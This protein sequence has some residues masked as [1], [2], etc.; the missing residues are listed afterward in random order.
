MEF[1][2]HGEPIF[3]TAFA[4][5]GLPFARLAVASILALSVAGCPSKDP[6][7]QTWDLHEAGNFEASIPVLRKAIEE[8]ADDPELLFLY[9]VALSETGNLDGAVWPLRKAMKSPEWEVRA[10]LLLAR[11]AFYQNSWDS[12]IDALDRVIELEPDHIFA[13]VTRSR[14]RIETRRDYEGALADAERALEIDPDAQGA[15]ICQVVALLGLDRPEEARKLIG[16]IEL[17]SREAESGQPD[18]ARFCAARATLATELGDAETA[19]KIYSECLKEFPGAPELVAEAVKLYGSTGQA[20]RVIEVLERAVEAAPQ[21]RDFRIGLALRLQSQGREAEATEILRKATEAKSPAVAADAWLDLG[22]Y[23]LDREEYDAGIEA[24]DRALEIVASPSGDLMFRYADALII[25]DRFDEALEVADRAQVTTYRDLIRGR[26]HLAQGQPAL[27]LERLTE[28][29][30]HWP[31]NAVAR[32]YTALAAEGVGNYARAVEEMRYSI[33]AG[34]SRTDARA[35]LARLHMAEGQWAEALGVLQ[36]DVGRQPANAEMAVLGIELA[37]RLGLADTQIGH[38]FQAL[39]TPEDRRLAILAAVRGTRARLGPAGAVQLIRA[40]P[41]LDLQD[42]ANAL[43]LGVLVENLIDAG[44]AEEATAMID[45]YVE[46]RPEAAVFHALRGRV[47]ARLE[48]DSSPNSRD[49]WVRALELDPDNV[50]ALR[51]LG[52]ERKAA[53]ELQEA[54]VYM[55]RAIE[56]APEDPEPI[57]AAIEMLI[58][59]GMASEAEPKLERLLELE[60]YDGAAALQL[61]RIRVQSNRNDERS[62]A[63]GQLAR[64]FGQAADRAEANELLQRLSANLP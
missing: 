19:G 30:E 59:D 42:P 44:R 14:A 45:G 15:R 7:Q 33:R 64:R 63:L 23:L 22:G 50:V 60:P 35:R 40:T 5:F 12:A 41:D 1:R 49:D 62:I 24:F 43:V 57:R 61:L 46:A 2:A 16:S 37:T 4:G 38:L 21:S 6:I 17:T 29:L 28:A 52:H 51:G 27:A 36:H 25:S 9:G 53:G 31:D 10:A 56:A 8:Q 32:Y 34:A 18:T 47:K 26:V 11:G 39:K 58:A 48:G 20:E 54:L 55:D 13:L 3:C